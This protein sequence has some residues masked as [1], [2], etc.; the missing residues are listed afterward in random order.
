MTR[1][2]LWGALFFLSA[3]AN[4]CAA[5]PTNLT[6]APVV[7]APTVILATVVPIPTLLPTVTLVPPP[8]AV[9]TLTV[10]PTARPTPRPSPSPQA[11]FSAPRALIPQAPANYRE[12]TDIEFKYG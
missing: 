3:L 4:A 5:P 10:T 7:G 1:L 12:G 8:T 9:P 11:R 6:P 2:K